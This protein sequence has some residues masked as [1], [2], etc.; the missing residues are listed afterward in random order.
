MRIVE[1][2]GHTGVSDPGAVA[3]GIREA[4]VNLDVGL[5]LFQKLKAVNGLEVRLTRDK[6]VDLAK[7]FSQAADLKI[8]TDMANAWQADLFLSIHCNAAANENAHGYETFIH[9]N[10]SAESRRVGQIIHK[11]M[12][13]LFRADRGLKTADFHV[14][15]E[16]RMPAV[17]VEMGF[18]TNAE[19]R[20]MLLDPDFR[21]RLSESLFR[22]ILEAYPHLGDTPAPSRTPIIGPQQATVEQAKAWAKA[23]GA[24]QRFIDIVESYWFWGYQFGIRPEVLYAQSAKETNFGKFTGQVTPEHNNWAGIKTAN[25]TGDRPEDHERFATPDEGVLAHFN[26]IAAYVGKDPFGKVHGRYNVVLSMPWAGKVWSVEELGGKW[27]PNPDYGNSV[28]RDY[29]NPLLATLP[30]VDWETRALTAE[31]EVKRLRDGMKALL[32]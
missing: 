32:G 21:E 18:V 31:A 27:A 14:L 25:A 30:P 22:A 23:R 6:H 9:V 3:P 26:H 11:H 17:L 4:D 28:V 5:R 10:A 16:T 19:D 13:P 12:A 29:L 15:R 20:A 7:P 8:R 24:H 1:D 2:L